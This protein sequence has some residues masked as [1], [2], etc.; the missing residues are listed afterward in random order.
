VVEAHCERVCDAIAHRG[1]LKP[2]RINVVVQGLK[3]DADSAVLSTL[4]IGPNKKVPERYDGFCIHVLI[5]I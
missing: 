1:R 3:G 4:A 5:F 2:K